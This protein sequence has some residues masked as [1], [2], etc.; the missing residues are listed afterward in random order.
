[1]KE[2]KIKKGNEIETNE[3]NSSEMKDQNE[4]RISALIVQKSVCSLFKWSSLAGALG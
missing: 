3:A 2:R 4:L 1:V